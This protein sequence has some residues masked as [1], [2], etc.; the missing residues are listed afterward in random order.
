M[1][2]IMRMPYPKAI[3]K[4]LLLIS[5]T[6]MAIIL[7]PYQA[8]AE[9]TSMGSVSIPQT[10]ILKVYPEPGTEGV[11]RN[12]LIYAKFDREIKESYLNIFTVYMK[13]ASGDS[14]YGKIKYVSGKATVYYIP[15]SALEPG[16]AYTV[17]IKSQVESVDG[18]TLD[19]DMTWSFTIGRP[20]TD[21]SANQID[22]SAV[23]TKAESMEFVGDG[24]GVA[25]RNNEAFDRIE[26]KRRQK[27]EDLRN[28]IMADIQDNSSADDL[29]SEMEKAA[30]VVTGMTGSR[31]DSSEMKSSL[32]GEPSSRKI[33]NAESETVTSK[34]SFLEKL[35]DF[36]RT[37]NQDRDES[38]IRVGLNDILNVRVYNALGYLEVEQDVAVYSDGCITFPMVGTVR[39]A[40]L[41]ANELVAAMKVPI[42]RDYLNN[43]RVEVR[44]KGVARE[45][46]M[47]NVYL[48]GQVKNPGLHSLTKGTKLLAAIVGVNG[49]TGGADLANAVIKRGSR[50]LSVDLSALI[51]AGDRDYDLELRDG[52]TIFIPEQKKK[53]QSIYVLGKVR[54]PSRYK[55]E[56]GMTAVD[57]LTLAEGLSEEINE[58]QIVRGDK[59]NPDVIQLDIYDI[60][61]KGNISKDISLRP[62]DIVY[63]QN[64]RKISRFDYVYIFSGNLA[65]GAN[66]FQG[67]Y[68]YSEGMTLLDVIALIKGLPNDLKW[69]HIIRSDAPPIFVDIRDLLNKG[70]LDR[71]VSLARGD[72]IYFAPIRYR[73]IVNRF[74]NFLSKTVIP[75]LSTLHGVWDGRK[76]Q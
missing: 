4:N 34:S 5:I 47:M 21:S 29:D 42:E 64:T 33:T 39:A 48:L 75:A 27:F 72:V 15:R 58:V 12:T 45:Q 66:A 3:T 67:R 25:V 9:Q 50:E 10:S 24:S 7:F 52:D 1:G 51:F 20:D 28:K 18:S 6:I 70:R 56:E 35:T 44:F 59:N 76:F 26:E 43:P 74:G 14:V 19:R 53:R 65:Y 54:Y 31:V 46:E 55:Y 38:R 16:K 57:A 32:K 41:T 30:A 36:N 40:G 71:D 63:V 11:S 60:I 49:T 73:N 69:V 17:T 37:E 68:D 61:R 22:S 8:F 2:N 23:E 13:D 62:G